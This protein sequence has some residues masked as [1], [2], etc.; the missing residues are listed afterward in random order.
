[1]REFFKFCPPELIKEYRKGDKIAELVNGA[2]I[3]F[4]SGDDERQVERMR[5][6]TI[7][8][9]ALDEVSLFDYMVWLI[10]IGRVRDE[11]GVMK[12]IC[13]GT[14]KGSR[15]WI[16]I[17]F[18]DGKNPRTGESLPDEYEWFSGTSFDNPYTPE[19]YKETIK[20]NYGGLFR[21]QELYGKF[22][23]A[24]GVVFSTFNRSI[25]VKKMKI[26]E[27]NGAVGVEMAGARVIFREIVCGI[28]FGFVHPAV[29]LVV[30]IDGDGRNYIIEEFCEKR[31]MSDRLIAKTIEIKERYNPTY[32]YCD[33]S[34]PEMIARMRLNGINARKGNNS[35]MDGISIIT[36]LLDVQP[37]GSSRLFVKEG[38]ANTIME[39][40]NYRYAEN[41][42][43]KPDKD[44]PI[45]IMDDCIDSLRYS[46]TRPG[47]KWHILEGDFD[48]LDKPV[49]TYNMY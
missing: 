38:L 49:N 12:G 25:H 11:K 2:E 24:E 39:F 42:D 37:N 46:L 15:H 30:G 43:G 1:M 48:V 8:G 13:A 35:V 14:P 47:Q 22:V 36:S 18:L 9:F 40:E 34:Q 21:E 3:L 44:R 31:C 23:T 28:D 17:M 20:M 7:G 4:I 41:P 16:K 32:Y 45:K 33:P 19:E 10:M 26:I 6:L 27:E 29:I 5:G